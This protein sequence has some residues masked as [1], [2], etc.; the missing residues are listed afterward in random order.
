LEAIILFRNKGAKMPIYKNDYIY[1]KMRISF[2]S[3]SI[4]MRALKSW[5]N[6]GLILTGFQ[7]SG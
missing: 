5:K 1:P 6:L 2:A 7:N 4:N 3:F